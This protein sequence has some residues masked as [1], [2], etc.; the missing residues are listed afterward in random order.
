[1]FIAAIILV[2]SVAATLQF[3]V[4]AWHAGVLRTAA[5]IELAEPER[6][7]AA[8]VRDFDQAVAY[9]Q[10]CPDLSSEAGP[11]LSGVRAYHGLLEAVSAVQRK[12]SRGDAQNSWA[13]REID[14]CRRYAQAALAERIQHNRAV[15][16][17]VGSF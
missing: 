13:S 4:L 14:L 15:L 10:L 2:L 5:Q 16:A 17:E 1:M 9:R 12:I 8:G 7:F 11:R 6:A 3:A